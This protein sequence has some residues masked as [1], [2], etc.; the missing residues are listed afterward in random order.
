MEENMTATE[1]TISTE[2]QN[3]ESAT[4]VAEVPSLPQE[5]TAQNDVTEQQEAE[6]AAVPEDE[7]NAPPFLSVRFNHQNRDMTREE[8]IEFAQ[9]GL[10]Y[11]KNRPIYDK[12]D[13]LAAQQNTN[14][15]GLADGLEEAAERAYRD[16]LTEKLG[17]DTQLVDEL[18]EL[19]RQRSK[20]KYDRQLFERAKA[21]QEAEERRK[22]SLSGQFD[23]LQK[24]F[25]EIKSLEELPTA[26]L[27]IAERENTNLISAYLLHRHQ[28]N[29]RIAAAEARAAEQ[30]KKTTGSVQSAENAE[31]NAVDAFIR[32]VRTMKH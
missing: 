1:S 5:D 17:E 31:A 24:E 12:L 7:E 9:K 18:M 8:A 32:G 4:E 13:Y 16:K 10:L 14:I 25:P 22:N 20:D 19:Y 15:S 3:T 28:E 30:S 21:E 11:E 27:Q 29:K 23:I 2:G 6:D 26:V